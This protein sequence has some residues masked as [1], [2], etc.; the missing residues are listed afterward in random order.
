M[1][2]VAVVSAWFNRS[3]FIMETVNAIC[4]QNY[5]NFSY[6]IVDDG[7]TDSRVRDL[8]A[9]IDDPRV[10]I[11]HQENAGFTQAISRAIQESDGEFIAIQGAG[12]V[13]LPDRLAAQVH[14]LQMNPDIGLV[15]CR[16]INEQIWP[17]GSRKIENLRLNRS[18]NR[19]TA[20]SILSGNPFS[21]GEV[22]IR[23]SAYERAG[24]YRAFF[25]KAQDKDLWLRIGETHRLAVLDELLYKRRV[26][27]S[28]GISGEFSASLE[29]IC[30]SRMASKC[31][32]ERKKTGTDSVSTF[33][34]AAFIRFPRDVETHRMIARRIIGS[35]RKN[36]ISY[37]DLRKV[38]SLF[39]SLSFL[40]ALSVLFIHRLFSMVMKAC[41]Q[42]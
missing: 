16:Y 42:K 37:H 8:M 33:G 7:S 11:I 6:T 23:K 18:V 5:K 26:F 3:D 13:S 27:V 35:N 12:D 20:E 39:G 1:A 30:F 15:G 31:Y 36:L 38:R 24:G 9:Q 40:F 14:F 34:D 29:Q 17:D 21:H 19:P 10:K 25:K 41:V 22:M 28:A 2:K 32:R 4:G